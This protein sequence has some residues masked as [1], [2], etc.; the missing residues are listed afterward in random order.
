VKAV[1]RDRYGPP[2][3][4]RVEDIDKPVPGQGEA[5]VRVHA[6]S[7]NTA[8]LH[9]VSGTPKA[10]RIGTGLT[11][12]KVRWIGLD[13]AGTVEGVGDGVGT[14]DPGDE[15]WADLSVVEGGA[16]AE[17]VC[18]PEGVFSPK[19]A[20]V[21]FEVAATMPHSAILALQGLRAW[22]RPI[23]P[24]HKVLINGAGGCVGPFA[25]EIAKANGA[26]V[27]GVDHAGKLDL[28]QSAGAD[29]VVDYTTEDVTRNGVLYDRI[30]DI[31]TGRSV[32]DF[33]RSLAPDGTHAVIV[34]S[35]GGF[36]GAFV[37][38]A[39]MAGSDKRM[40]VFMWKPNDRDDLGHLA[41]LANSGELSPII[42]RRVGLEEI[43]G[44]L[45]DMQDGK[46]RGKVVVW[47]G[48]G[49]RT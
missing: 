37:N 19:P 22:N 24:G 23:I 34:D 12:P 3:V 11:A 40:G 2:A 10:A 26:E 16:F 32:R 49:E 20:G 4:L 8:D 27:T 1:V 48:S 46:T 31:A 41:R 42:D 45:H 29:H 39:M 25:I 5:L 13:I 18:A 35:L 33:R 21:G 38:G 15:V 14:L 30:L 7:L 47:I 28:M 9:A 36:F 44:A 43:P 6:S 17:Y